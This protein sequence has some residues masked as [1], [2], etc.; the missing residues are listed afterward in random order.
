MLSNKLSYSAQDPL[1][2]RMEC[3]VINRLFMI[4]TA[5][6]AMLVIVLI[7]KRLSNILTPSHIWIKIGYFGMGIYIYQQFILQIIYYHTGIPALVGIYLLPWLGFISAFIVSFLFTHCLSKFR[8][9]RALLG[10]KV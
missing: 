10:D 4:L 1:L 6:P 2:L 7:G 5:M 9:G 8:I 3:N